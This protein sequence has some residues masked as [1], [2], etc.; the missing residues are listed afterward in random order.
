[1]KS[2]QVQGFQ[3]SS[4]LTQAPS[5]VGHLHWLFEILFQSEHLLKICHDKAKG[6][7]VFRDWPWA[8]HGGVWLWTLF[9]R[10]SNG[11][12]AVGLS[13][14][15]G[16]HSAHT[17]Q[18]FISGRGAFRPADLTKPRPWNRSPEIQCHAHPSRSRPR[19]VSCWKGVWW[20]S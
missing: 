12:S 6:A 19:E 2:I 4:A 1:M 8:D 10:W 7:F 15:R 14:N 18:R 16:R 9:C 17:Y 3:N 5:A 11:E 20:I 13:E